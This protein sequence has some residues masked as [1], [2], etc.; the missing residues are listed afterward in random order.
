MSQDAIISQSWLEFNSIRHGSRKTKVWLCWL[1]IWNDY[2]LTW[3]KAKYGNIS[4]IR[5]PPDRVWQPDI[6]LFNK[7]VCSWSRDQMCFKDIRS[8]YVAVFC[9][10]GCK[11][12]STYSTSLGLGQH[13]SDEFSLCIT[14]QQLI[15]HCI[16]RRRLNASQ[17][18]FSQPFWEFFMS[19]IY[20]SI[21]QKD[22]PNA[23]K[24]LFFVWVE[25]RLNSVPFGLTWS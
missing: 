10:R 17:Y 18:Y 15:Y 20:F 25:R 9:R 12:S 6:V 3:E 22:S 16:S 19:A 13:P 21:T 4:V 8:S 24:N 23:Q 2:Q 7:W 11:L 14:F 1:Q 5:I